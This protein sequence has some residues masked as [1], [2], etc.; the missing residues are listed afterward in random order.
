MEDEGYSQLP[1]SPRTRQ[2]GRDLDPKR[3]DELLKKV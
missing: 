3:L 1:T 2:R